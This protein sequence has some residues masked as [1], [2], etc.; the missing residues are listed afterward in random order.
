MSLVISLTCALLATL[1]QQWARRYLKV[2]PSRYTLHKRARI[3]VFLAKGVEKLLLQWT[4]EMLPT[5]LHISLFLF[6]AGLVV[7][8]WN[9]DLTI[10]KWVLSWVGVCTALYGCFTAMPIIRHDSPYRTPLSLP[11]WHIVTGIQHLTFRALRLLSL[12]DYFSWRTYERFRGLAERYGERLVQGM[13]KTV[14]ETAEE[15]ALNSP[16][17]IDIHAFLWTLDCSDEDHELERF[18]SGIPGFRSSNV[19]KDPFP[20]LTE[21][22][23]EGLFNAMTGLLDRTFASD[24]LPQTIKKR[25]A[26]ICTKA[27][28]PAHTPEA[29]RVLNEILFQ[30]QFSDPLVAEVVQIVRGWDMDNENGI[31]DAKALF[32]WIFSRARPRGDDAWFILASKLMGIPEDDLR[33]YAAHGDSL[34]LAILIYVTRQHFSHFGKLTRVWTEIWTVL[35]NNALFRVRN[36]LP[37]LQREFCALWDQ[38][39]RKVWNEAYPE[40]AHY[41]LGPIGRI[42]NDLHRTGLAPTGGYSDPILR[43]VSSYPLC[44]VAGHHPDSTAY[45][46]VEWVVPSSPS[47]S[48]YTPSSSLHL[49][50]V[51]EGVTEVPPRNNNISSSVSLR[52]PI[53]HWQTTTESRC[54]PPT[55]PNPVTARAT[56]GS[57]DT[58]HLSTLEPSTSTPPPKPRASASPPDAVYVEH[59]ADGSA[60]FPDV[61]SSHLPLR[62]S[63]QVRH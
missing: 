45:T 55:S 28:D 42:Y 6:F 8:L 17:E 3:R 22:R 18:F 33:R 29:F 56:R 59:N 58:I 49:V 47:G 63:L 25:R 39:V 60:P 15:T 31:G 11:V 48:P 20:Y 44:D 12:V 62:L 46:H 52:Q 61:P 41:I 35:S 19:V 40:K 16:L 37:E 53:V 43:H 13:Q 36:T 34:S 38:I 14:E 5:L 54:T 24:L 1:L 57:V 50:R 4:V 27:I 10:F 21:E 9:V 23:K 30:Y 32:I 51:D 26:I 2:T 7:F